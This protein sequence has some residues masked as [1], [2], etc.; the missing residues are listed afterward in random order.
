MPRQHRSPSLSSARPRPRPGLRES[1]AGRPARPPRL[2][3]PAPPGPAQPRGCLPSSA[4]VMRSLPGPP[5]QFLLFGLLVLGF[6]AARCSGPEL[7][8][9]PI[10]PEKEP[11]PARGSAGCSFGGKLYAL[12]ETWHPDL[13][14]P[15]GVMRCVLC[16]CELPSWGRRGRGPGR[17][18]CKNIK[19]ECPVPN[20]GQPRQ[21]PGHCC[22]TCPPERTPS[23]KQNSASAF[24]YPRDPE[25][26]S[27]SNRG[28]PGAEKRAREDGHTDFVALLTGRGSQAVAR[29]R[30]LLLRS[31]LRFSVSY[32]GMDRVTRVRFTDPS[33][34]IL[35]EHPA[36]QAQDGLVCGMWRALPRQSLRLLRAEQLHV[37]LVTPTHPSG[38]VWGPLIRHRELA[39]ETFSAILTLEGPPQANTGGIALLTLSDTED[40]LHFLLLSQGLLDSKNG[41]SFH[42]PLRLQIQHEDQLLRELQANVSAQEPGFAEVLPDLTAQEMQWLA[43]GELQISLERKEGPGPRISGHITARQSCDTL[44]SVL[45]GADALV[46]VQTGAAGSASLRLLRNGSLLYQVQVV[47]TASEVTTVTLETKPRRRD[48]HSVLCQMPRSQQEGHVV[49]GMCPGLGAR[50]VHMLLQNELFLNVGTK[51]FPEGELR[52]HVATVPYSGYSARQDMLP[53]PLAGALAL[54]PIRSQAAGHAWLFLD[55]HCHL[56]YEVLLAGLSGSEQGTV[57]IHLI[58]P[59]GLPGPQR[60]LK[61]FYGPEAQGIVKDLESELLHHLSQG[62]AF[63]LVSTK[64]SPRGELRGQVHIPNQCEV[65]S[66]RLAAP[67][68]DRMAPDLTAAAAPMRSLNSEA[69]EVVASMIPASVGPVEAQ[70]MPETSVSAVPKTGG[71]G[72]L[73]DPNT[74]FFEGQQRPHGAHWAPNY[75]PVCSLCTCQRRT[76]ICDPVVCPPLSCPHPVQAP[77]QCC[78][79][80]PKK[81]D[82]GDRQGLDRSRDP[83]EGCYFDGDRSWRAAGTRWHPVVPPFGLIKCAV[84]TCKGAT[85]EVH[86]EKVQCPRLTCAQPIRANPTDCCKQ[87]PAG[88]GSRAW[89]GDP[90]QAD[91]PRGCRF[92]GQWFPESQRW[93]PSVPPFGEMTCITCRCGAGVPHCERDDCPPA[94]ACG[95]GKEDRC[96]SRCSPRPPETRMEPEL[97]KE[98]G[99]S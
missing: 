41:G 47:G 35:F 52:G 7:P 87:C 70:P 39:A 62:M 84:C 11:L 2:A 83:G 81:S 58:G 50:G 30:V 99:D 68:P 63:L 93:H 57:T 72:H 12:E 44:Q 59:P 23:E 40:S 86:C 66:L 43:L 55:G 49:V 88:S 77:D 61:G 69:P 8:Q 26:R 16:A 22:Q 64:S 95:S 4:R 56:H 45:C 60:L 98:A 29:T 76:V 96:C 21:L 10:R 27:Y 46:P 25:H 18:S 65:G 73:R 74:C 20:C 51:D 48:Q 36:P 97:E 42:T 13:G 71:G 34:S 31:T 89:L 19:P 85:G 9:L 6:R 38:E 67:L 54:P 90:M 24:E 82:I 15:F 28:D 1:P 14:E 33:G 17:V 75:D 91:G 94:L 92:G 32:R 80:C 37:V 5:A 78:P 79:V 3:S 53:V